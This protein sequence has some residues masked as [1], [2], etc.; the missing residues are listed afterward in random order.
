MWFDPVYHL[1]TESNNTGCYKTK[2]WGVLEHSEKRRKLSAQCS[3]Q[4]MCKNNMNAGLI[5]WESSKKNRITHTRVVQSQKNL[6]E[7]SNK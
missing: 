5:N 4:E 1:H 2:Y 3:W 7:S 6:L